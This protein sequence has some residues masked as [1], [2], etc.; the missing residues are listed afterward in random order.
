M[1]E[2]L[3]SQKVPKELERDSDASKPLTKEHD[4]YYLEPMYNYCKKGKMLEVMMEPEYSIWY[5]KRALKKAE[6]LYILRK[7]KYPLY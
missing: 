1:N 2:I 4:M 3:R 6:N 7:E 5:Y